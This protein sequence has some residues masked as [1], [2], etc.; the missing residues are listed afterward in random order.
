MTWLEIQPQDVWLFRDGKPFAAGEDHSAHSMF[1]PTPLTVQGALRQKISASL[2]VSLREYKAAKT[3]NARKAV[4]YIGVHGELHQL[5][6][7]GMRGPFVSLRADPD[8]DPVPL[9]PTPADLLKRH[10]TNEFY[11]SKPSSTLLSDLGGDFRFPEVIEKYENLPG[12][13]MALDTFTQYLN[14]IAPDKSAYAVFDRDWEEASEHEDAF[15][16]Y[17]KGKRIW[18]DKFI[19]QKD[20]R[21][22]VSTNAQTCFREEGQLYQVQFVRPQQGIGLLVSVS[23]AIPKKLLAGRINLGGEQRQAKAALVS[24]VALPSRPMSNHFKIIFLT[25]TYFDDGW[26]PHEGD[27]SVVFG[28]SV[29]L[30]S[31]NLYRPIK[32]GGWN[33]ADHCP[34]TMHNYVS[35]G[36][37]YYFETDDPFSPP[38]A[39]TQNPEGINAPALGFGQ[40]AI[41]QW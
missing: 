9:L 39:L 3:D 10:E 6:K 13:W 14:D 29:K 15:I 7:F 40:Y 18:S 26:Q 34:R 27:W 30:I 24:N 36:S 25:P 1:P 38:D 33:S 4:E 11:I 12:C 16:T 35:S 20:D 28:K 31:A 37:V 8:L 2:G 17:S 5:G 23:D 19:Y 21:F 41:G 32:I 22:G